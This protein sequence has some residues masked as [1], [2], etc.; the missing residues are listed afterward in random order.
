MPTAE[1]VR[2]NVGWPYSRSASHGVLAPG[3]EVRVTIPSRI[4]SANGRWIAVGSAEIRDPDNP[5]RVLHQIPLQPDIRTW[6][7]IPRKRMLHI[8]PTLDCGLTLPNDPRLANRE[9]DVRVKLEVTYPVIVLEPV[10]GS[11]GAF[12]RRFLA[13]KKETLDEIVT[14][15]VVTTS[16]QWIYAAFGYAGGLGGLVLCLVGGLRLT[17]IAKKQVVSSPIV[18]PIEHSSRWQTESHA[19][20]R[21]PDWQA[22]SFETY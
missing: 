19:E 18:E 4:R 13:E 12:T 16:A 2:R 10:P 5:E 22:K 20:G 17:Q 8:P 9:W 21:V 3:S 6:D 7:T 15:E 1:I 11:K 14:L